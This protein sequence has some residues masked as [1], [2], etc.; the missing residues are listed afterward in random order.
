MGPDSVPTDDGLE[1]K[2]VIVNNKKLTESE[3][4][5]KKDEIAKKPGAKLVEVSPGVY[6][7]RLKG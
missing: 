7:I 2:T 1:K 4:Q 5:V 3:F 6:K